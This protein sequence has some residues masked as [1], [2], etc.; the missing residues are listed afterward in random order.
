[1]G[2][3]L[4]APTRWHLRPAEEALRNFDSGLDGLAAEV[5]DQ[6]LQELG[7]NEIPD[8]RRRT[9]VRI[10]VGQLRSPF[11][12]VLEGAMAITVFLQH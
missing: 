2:S 5:A 8:A 1:M 4:S 6:R 12:F 7:P 11:L 3:T 9:A 10:L